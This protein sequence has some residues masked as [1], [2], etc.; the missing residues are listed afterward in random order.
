M[1]AA[2]SAAYTDA[3]NQIVAPAA[4]YRLPDAYGRREFADAGGLLSYGTSF[5]DLFRHAA[6]YV[7]KNP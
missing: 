1:M 6:V 2:E 3:R 7:D 4:R 5:P